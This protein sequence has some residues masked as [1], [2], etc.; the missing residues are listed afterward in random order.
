MLGVR[1][2]FVRLES[3]FAGKTYTQASI[4]PYTVAALH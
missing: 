4:R 3:R 2:M 1:R